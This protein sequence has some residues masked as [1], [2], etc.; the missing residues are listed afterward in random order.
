MIRLTICIRNKL[1]LDKS[2]YDGLKMCQ[3]C[4]A[5]RFEIVR[6]ITQLINPLMAAMKVYFSSTE[7]R[8]GKSLG[9]TVTV[10][11]HVLILLFLLPS[12][13]PTSA[14]QV[15][16]TTRLISDTPVE[17]SEQVPLQ[18]EPR[19]KTPT[20]SLQ[21]PDIAVASTPSTPKAPSR[22]IQAAPS[23][24]EDT[25]EQKAESI[26]RFDA[27][28]L[29]NPAPVYPRVSR[30][31]REVGVVTLRVFVSESGLPDVIELE[32]SS[33]FERLDESAL[34]TVRQ[35]KFSPAKRAGHAIGAWVLVPIEF[36]LNT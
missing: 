24:A 8:L 2:P 33:G 32:Q 36:S 7:N 14:P 13:V 19:F 6:A 12:Q 5:R 21:M 3:E 26:P 16:V 25:A 23:R 27:D 34:A 9:L 10:V 11:V 29:N 20:L 35:W 22:E 30:R 28:Y 18:S 1:R 4:A 15:L 31:L 17:R